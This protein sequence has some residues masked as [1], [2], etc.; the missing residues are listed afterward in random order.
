M[1]KRQ[2]PK[3]T[4]EVQDPGDQKG[5]DVTSAGKKVA[6]G[7]WGLRRWGPEMSSRENRVLQWEEVPSR[8]GEC[9]WEGEEG[10]ILPQAV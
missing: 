2:N 10:M 7:R 9:H 4:V 8:W 5:L 1:D 6:R 3:E